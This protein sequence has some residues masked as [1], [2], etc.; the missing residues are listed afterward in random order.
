MLTLIALVATAAASPA[1]LP[2]APAA[3]APLRAMPYSPSLDPAAMDTKIDACTDFYQFSCGGWMIGNPIP[4]DQA[5]WSVYGKLTEDTQRYLWGILDELSKPSAA[6]TPSQQKIGDFFAACMDEGAIEAQGLKPLKP[7][8][9]DVNAL[10]RIQDLAPLLAKLH[11]AAMGFYDDHLLFS[12]GSQQ[13][14]ED[15]SHMIADLGS[16]GLGLPDR[17][18]YTR[19][20]AKSKELQAQYRAHVQAMLEL[21]GEKAKVAARDAQAIYALED[22]LARASLT[23]VERRDPHNLFHR[24]TVAELKKLTPAF[25]WA[26]YLSGAGLAGLSTLNVDQPAFETALQVALTRV[27][28]ATWKAYLRWHVVH[29][30]ADNL[31]KD[32]VQ[33]DFDFYRHKLRGVPELKPR[34]K[35]CVAW[36][37]GLLGEALGQE[38]VNRVLTPETKKSALEMTRLIEGAMEDDLKSLAW[39]GPKPREE[40]L[41]K[42]HA[43]HNKLGYPDSWRDY[44]PVAV[45]RDDF[46]GDVVRAQTFETR[47]WLAKVGKPVDPTEWFMTP[48]TVNAYYD[49]Q[50]N[51]INFPAGVLQPPLYD[52][53]LDDAPNYGNT[54]STIGHELTH[55]FDDEGRQF[56]SKGNLRDWWGPTDGKAF[57]ERAQC[58]VDQYGKYPVVDEIKINSKLTE[59]EDIADLGGTVLAYAAWKKAVAGKTLTPVGGF[60]PDQRFFIGLAQW[61][62][63]NQRPENLR[64]QA[65]TNPH[66]PGRYRINGVVSNLP[67]FQ[68]A[69]SCKPD[70]PM[71]NPKPCRVW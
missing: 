38:F 7:W 39:M 33:L 3:E 35:R 61:A 21:I 63:E 10:K 40:A 53:K 1:E 69:F 24:T 62:C 46:L 30:F 47:R 26:A 37:D 15:S 14:F 2:A 45:T 9:D 13:D 5:S 18:Y 71:V 11:L 48:P 60:T 51:D 20:D 56:D 59:G 31:S 70:A 50:M 41:Q 28:L 19:T 52:L 8:L 29:A 67:E 25:D 57:Q 34:W 49:P 17:D 64:M 23:L 65:L 27:P 68:K 54:G 42:L 66:S 4:A 6:R 55:A 12:F 36:V 22:R 16:G 44:G 32:A 58:V 43:I